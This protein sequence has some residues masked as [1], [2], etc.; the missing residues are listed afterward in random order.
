MAD[1]TLA[2]PRA[3]APPLHPLTIPAPPM[4][5]QTASAGPVVRGDERRRSLSVEEFEALVAFVMLD[6]SATAGAAP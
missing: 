1:W 5:P 3:Q 6:L 4:P 2:R